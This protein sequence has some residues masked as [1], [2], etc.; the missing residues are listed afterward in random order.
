MAWPPVASPPEASTSRFPSSD[1]NYPTKTAREGPAL[2]HSQEDE[3]DVQRE[4]VVH[5]S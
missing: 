4:S 5:D 1:S 3:P 2:S